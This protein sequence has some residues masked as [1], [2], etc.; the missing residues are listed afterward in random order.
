MREKIKWLNN[1]KKY[2]F[3]EYKK[4]DDVF[5]HYSA[6]LT[7]DYKVQVESEYVEFEPVKTGKSLQYKNVIELETTLV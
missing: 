4:R 1:E 6:I 5:V 3:I 2:N 7:L